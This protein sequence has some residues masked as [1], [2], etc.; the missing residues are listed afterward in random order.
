MS[1]DYLRHDNH[2]WGRSRPNL[3]MQVHIDC[4]PDICATK[5]AAYWALVDAGK[6]VPDSN[7]NRA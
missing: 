7:R 5:A 3:A 1:L 4:H 6:L 2:E